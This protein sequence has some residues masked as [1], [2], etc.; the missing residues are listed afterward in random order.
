MNFDQPSLSAGETRAALEAYLARC[1]H[2]S[3][4]LRTDPLYKHAAA[5][6]GVPTVANSAGDESGGAVVS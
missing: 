5:L 1:F 2:S 6:L 4:E 3:P